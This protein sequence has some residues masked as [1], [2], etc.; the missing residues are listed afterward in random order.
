MNCWRSRVSRWF[1]TPG[2]SC[3][4]SVMSLQIQNLCHNQVNPGSPVNFFRSALPRDPWKHAYRELRNT[5]LSEARAPSPWFLELTGH[6]QSFFMASSCG[7]HPL[8]PWHNAY[9][10]YA[11]RYLSWSIVVSRNTVYNYC[12]VLKK[13]WPPISSRPFNLLPF[14]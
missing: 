7:R 1:E 12:I 6:D 4:V 9:R 11:L 10:V 13:K 8:R 14:W 2:R 5:S 3:Y